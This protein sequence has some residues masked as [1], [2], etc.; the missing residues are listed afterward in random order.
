METKEKEE[1]YSYFYL[2]SAYVY[3]TIHMG[4]ESKWSAFTVYM[5]V[6]F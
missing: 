3:L 2:L 4:K 1:K 6:R 5:K